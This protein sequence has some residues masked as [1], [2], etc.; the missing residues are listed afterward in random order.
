MPASPDDIITSSQEQ[1]PPLI[2]DKED[3]GAGITMPLPATE[4]VNI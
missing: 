4:M 2:A 1:Q 3:K